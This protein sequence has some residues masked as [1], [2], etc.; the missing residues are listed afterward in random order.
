MITRKIRQESSD[1]K[2]KSSDRSRVSHR[3]KNCFVVSVH[4]WSQLDSKI[5][6]V[7]FH[8]EKG[9][10]GKRNLDSDD[11]H[12][13][14]FCREDPTGRISDVCPT[15]NA[16][17]KEWENTSSN[18][19]DSRGHEKGKIKTAKHSRQRL[20]KKTKEKE[21]KGNVVD[22]LLYRWM[23]ARYLGTPVVFRK[24]YY[25]QVRQDRQSSERNSMGVCDA[26]C[27]D[28]MTREFLVGERLGRKGRAVDSVLFNIHQRIL[29]R[30]R[31]LRSR[32][33]E[34]DDDPFQE[35]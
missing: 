10:V 23:C 35:S 18:V 5:S 27:N 2:P 9:L 30:V 22:A 8:D 16:K 12:R 26:Q 3:N 29:R 1:I 21:R 13:H 6:D 14:P 19:K 34:N 7:S 31:R 11:F 24:V 15:S 25:D 20:E 17:W 32:K 4:V 33:S 28:R